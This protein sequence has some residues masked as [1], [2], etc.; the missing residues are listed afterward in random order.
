MNGLVAFAHALAD[1]TRLR[2][3][4]LLLR[5]PLCVCELADILSMPQSSVSSHVQVVRRAGLLESERREKWIYYRVTPGY[6]GLIQELDHFFGVSRT[7]ERVLAEDAARAEARL[8]QRD[9]RCCPAPVIL[10]SRRRRATSR[11]HHQ[12]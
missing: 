10:D 11:T 2:I 6:A 7:G 5:E 3:L 12:P 8:A 4:H 9:N 1:E